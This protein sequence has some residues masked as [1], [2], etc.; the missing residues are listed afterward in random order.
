MDEQELEFDYD[1][2]TLM[3]EDGNEQEFDILDAVETDSAR[4]VALMPI[5]ESADE[6]LQSSGELLVMRVEEEDD[7]E[8]L[9]TI[10]DDDE[11][12]EILSAFEERLSE[13]YEIDHEE[14]DQ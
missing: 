5:F 12:E 14:D 6:A 10:D 7:G 2:V 3:D 11:F 8:V 13:Y 1:T 9:V 4:Y